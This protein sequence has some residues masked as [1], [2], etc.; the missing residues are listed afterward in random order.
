MSQF[1][2]LKRAVEKAVEMRDAQKSFFKNKDRFALQS[3]KTLE[4]EFD[5]LASDALRSDLLDG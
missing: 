4:R 1:E 2:R 5:K 3:S